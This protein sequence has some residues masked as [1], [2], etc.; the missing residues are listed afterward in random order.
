M[1]NRRRINE[2]GFSLIEASL[3]FVVIVLLATAAG[4]VADRQ[5]ARQSQQ[6]QPNVIQLGTAPSSRTP[7]P[8]TT[9]LELSALGIDIIVPNAINDMTYAAP[10]PANG[11]G[12]G[13]STKTL[14]S[15][16][17]NCIATGNNPPLGNFFKV[18]GQYSSGSTP[19]G[20]LARQ[21]ATYYIAWSSPQAPCSSSSAV[22]QLANTRALDLE[23][24]FKTIEEV[25]PTN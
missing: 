22:T 5:T 18:P 19:P 17:A 14:T 9:T 25:P 4:L 12:Y 10:N 7:D 15:Q 23:N 16:D 24:S 11:G 2:D 21:F 6:L 8:A 1:G 20:K 3:V 13:I